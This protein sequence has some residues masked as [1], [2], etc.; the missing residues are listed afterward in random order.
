MSKE[1]IDAIVSRCSKFSGWNLVW[2]VDRLKDGR[3]TLDIS[4]PTDETNAR[5]SW[6]SLVANQEI[7][8]ENG[9]LIA[10]A[11]GLHELYGRMRHWGIDLT[12]RIAIEQYLRSL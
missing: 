7:R 3:P 2:V 4:D 12:E 9:S 11:I 5:N 8:D 1:S 10:G 6:L